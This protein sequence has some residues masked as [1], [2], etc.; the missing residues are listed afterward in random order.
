MQLF[1]FFVDV[2]TSHSV[3]SLGQESPK[4]PI[5]FS[6][7]P[8]IGTVLNEKGSDAITLFINCM[9]RMMTD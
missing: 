6:E 4:I 2:P 1:F 8:W 5:S 9:V 7:G 3:S